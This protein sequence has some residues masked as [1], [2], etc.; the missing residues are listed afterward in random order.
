MSPEVRAALCDYIEGRDK[1][2]SRRTILE[3]ADDVRH[4]P[5]G[6]TPPVLFCLSLEDYEEEQINSAVLL[7]L[8]AG[9]D[10]QPGVSLAIEYKYFLVLKALLR[11]GATV[12]PATFR[13]LEDYGPGIERMADLF[14]AFPGVARAFFSKPS[15]F[16]SNLASDREYAGE[17]RYA[18]SLGADADADTWAGSL[19]HTAAA[20]GNVPGMR[21]LLEFGAD[22]HKRDCSKR[23]AYRAPGPDGYPV[24]AYLARGG[25]LDLAR[26]LI[27]H[28]KDD[29]HLSALTG[30]LALAT[31]S[32]EL[33]QMTFLCDLG[34]DPS[35]ALAQAIKADF[36]EGVLALLERGAD[37]NRV[38]EGKSVL[39]IAVECA[40]H[41]GD[42][43]R[44]GD[45][46]TAFPVA[47]LMLDYGADPFARDSGG[48]L[49]LDA[50]F[51]GGQGQMDEFRAAHM[52]GALKE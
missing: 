9:A 13:G 19:F 24:Y 47:R 23:P 10:P 43:P 11:A 36:T 21:I 17:L 14:Y 45:C 2:A 28:E 6:S 38:E 46:P 35:A 30:S 34:A 18:L 3:H 20:A 50:H 15:R 16:L 39:Q 40:K 42:A 52:A 27:A 33:S 7:L 1:E 32:L 12:D 29:L 44:F 49:F 5:H 51:P 37:A 22:M 4:T 41:P 25:N 26:A 48:A 8:E 31:R